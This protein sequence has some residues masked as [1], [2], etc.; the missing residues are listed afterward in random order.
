M[1]L[2]AG[3]WTCTSRGVAG[4][5]LGSTALRRVLLG[6]G[7]VDGRPVG[8]GLLGRVDGEG[9]PDGEGT[10]LGVGHP[11]GGV[12][13][14]GMGVGSSSGTVWVVGA[15][16]VGDGGGVHWRGARGR[17]TLVR[18]GEGTGRLGAGAAAVERTAGAGA[19]AVRVGAGDG[20]VAEVAEVEGCAVARRWATG[21]PSLMGSGFGCAGVLGAEGL[22]TGEAAGSGWLTWP[23]GATVF[24]TAEVATAA[25]KR[26]EPLFATLMGCHQCCGS[27]LSTSES[28][29][30]EVNGRFRPTISES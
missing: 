10:E 23:W 9:L 4:T 22:G 13:R 17:P 30:T 20:G 26:M 29:I 16:H 18:V 14:P 8:S 5:R 19:G 12:E 11:T 3:R 15:F 7:S 25:R 24:T 2:V 1:G 21:L 28:T 6:R 27:L